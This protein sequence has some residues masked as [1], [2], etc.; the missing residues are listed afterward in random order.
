M[1]QFKNIFLGK[2]NPEYKKISS[3]QACVRAGG[4]HND[5]EHVGTNGRHHTFFEMLGNFSFNSYFKKEA[6]EYAWEY[7]TCHLKL[8]PKNLYITTHYKD[9]ESRKLWLNSIKIKDNHLT[10]K[11]DTDNFWSMD[12][13]G[14]C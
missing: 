8:P 7:L 1:V 5:L 4:K 10:E 14:P 11:G 6:I 3:C 9:K 2:T 13:V 12:T